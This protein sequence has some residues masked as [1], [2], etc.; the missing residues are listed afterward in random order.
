[1]TTLLGKNLKYDLNA[2]LVVFLVAL[3]LCL[4]IAIASGAPPMSGLIAGI[5]GGIVVG[6]LSGS[7]VSVSGPAAGLT[8]IVLDSINSMG[9]F[10]LFLATIV[11]AGLIQLALGLAKA[12][13]IGYYFPH[14]VIKGMLTAIGLILILKQIPHAFGYDVDLMGDQAFIQADNH[15]TFSA[16]WYAIKY[17]SIGAI[18]IVLVAMAILILFENP[19]IKSHKLLGI[20]PGALWAVISGIVINSLYGIWKPEWQLGGDHLV[21]IPVLENLGQIGNLMT[22]PDFSM[23]GEGTFWIVAATI[24]I[25]GSLETLLSIDASDKLDPYKRTS[26]PSKELVAQGIGNTLS[27]LIGGLPVTA[28]IVRSSANV[29]SGAKTK[30]SAIFHGVLLMILVLA[31]PNVLNLI[32]LSCLAAVLFIV[33]YK[34]AKPSIFISIYKNGWDQFIPFI[35]TVVAILFT[36]LLVG[37]GIGMVF[38]LFF[39]IKTNFVHAV[40]LTELNGNY[41]VQLHKDVS[42]LNKAL[43][44]KNLEKIPAESKV[45]INAQKAQ[46]I[47]HDIQ[48]VLNDF[49]ASSPDKKIKVTVIGLNYKIH[50]KI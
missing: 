25:I 45:I 44:M 41:L 42:F 49:I 8:V 28:V 43:L 5:V 9:T 26:P 46:F 20:V 22:F 34:L 38:G 15:N 48:E 13:V 16:I 29:A 47:D 23:I 33:G 7:H 19:K 35:V 4:G 36:D 37:I 40:T 12:G 27:G 3:P 50:Q 17:H 32:P 21:N 24:A 31:I 14:S 6:A 1:M 2:S 11:I 10:P 18:P 39:V 30:M